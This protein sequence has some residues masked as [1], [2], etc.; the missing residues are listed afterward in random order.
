MIHKDKPVISAIGS[1]HPHI[2][3]VAPRQG[4][5]LLVRIKTA[6]TALPP[7]SD[8][9]DFII[10]GHPLPTFLL[11]RI[12]DELKPERTLPAPPHLV[13]LTDLR[14]PTS[15]SITTCDLLTKA[16]M[17]WGRVPSGATL[18]HYGLAVFDMDSTLITIE[19]IDELADFAGKKKEVS[20]ITEQ[21]MSGQLDY[22]QS[23]LKRVEVL[24]GMDTRVLAQV[25]AERL[26]LS[27]GAD[28][29]MATLHQ[30]GLRTALLSGGFTYFTERIK[31]EMGLD[32]ATSNQLEIESG[33]LTGRVVGEI[34]D[35]DAKARHLVRLSQ[36][37]GLQTAQVIAIGDGANDLQMMSKAGL[38][39]GFHAKPSVRA[40][41]NIV[42]N[43]G[44]LDSLLNFLPPF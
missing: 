31:I 5:R 14:Q 40:K 2:I 11:D 42:I 38:S 25:Y 33:C 24:R 34:I 44:G 4:Q 43:D 39:V 27:E 17:N 10:A 8:S 18:R 26:K 41:A 19:C 12:V 13:H 1:L 36:E 15:L 32:F 29:L 7:L 22:R 20:E 35:A 16:G 30:N 21:A 28:R 3:P 37:F 23:L 6:M 9:M